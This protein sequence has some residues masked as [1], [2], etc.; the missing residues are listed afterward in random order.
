MSK[1]VRWPVPFA[2][3][4]YPS[5]LSAFSHSAEQKANRLNVVVS[6]GTSDYPK[7]LISFT[8]VLVFNCFDEGCAPQREWPEVEVY[9]PKP[10]AWMW[11]DSPWVASYQGCGQYDEDD[12]PFP[13]YHYLIFGGDYNVEVVARNEPSVETIDGPG[14]LSLEFTV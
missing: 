5:V 3:A 9:D 10:C 7:F 14:D 1:L 4:F 2:D 8:G 11:A 6:P 13:L 12:Q